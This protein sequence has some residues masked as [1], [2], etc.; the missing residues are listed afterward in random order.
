MAM[1]F[2]EGCDNMLYPAENRE[3]GQLIFYCKTCHRNFPSEENTK[4]TNLVYRNEVKLSQRNIM[5]DPGI[6]NDPTYARVKGIK[7]PKC[8]YNEAIYFQNPNINDPGMKFLFVCCKIYPNG[9]YCGRWWYKESEGQV[10][11]QN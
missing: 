11:E 8:G 7:C 10:E 2:C 6:I 1:R 9:Q 4:E 3:K 5:I